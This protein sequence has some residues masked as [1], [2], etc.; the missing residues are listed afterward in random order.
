[1]ASGVSTQ[2]NN[3]FIKGEFKYDSSKQV[4]INRNNDTTI[5]IPDLLISESLTLSDDITLPSNL[6]VQSGGSLTSNSKTFTKESY[7]SGNITINTG[8]T[9]IQNTVFDSCGLVKLVGLDSNATMSSL[10]LNT[11]SGM[12]ISGGSIDV[13][14]LTIKDA[15]EQFLVTN[16]AHSG[17]ISNFTI[18]T[19][20]DHDLSFINMASGVSTEFNNVF[21]KGEFKYASSKEVLINRN[22]DTNITIPDLLISESLLVS[23]DISLSGNLVVQNGGL[24]SSSNK[25]FS[26]DFS[27][28]SANITI[29]TGSSSL[30]S[31]IFNSCGLLK[32]VSL[33]NNATMS[34]LTLNTC[35]GMEINGG[36]IDVSTLTIKDA[37][38]EFLVTNNAHSGTISNF[39]I[40]TTVD[41]DLSFINMASGVST[42]FN[43]VFIKGDFKYASSKPVL[44]NRNSDTNIT[45]PDLLIS[46]SLT[47]SDDITLP[48]NLVVQSSGS[49]ISNDKT[50]DKESYALGNITINTGSSSL[51]S[52]TFNS[53]GLLK[54]V[55]LDGNAT[56]S[57][58]TLN[59]CTGMEING[60][61][62]DV[63][64]LTIK[65]ASDEFLVT[66]N[67]HSG[68]ISNFTIH[69]TVDHDLS[70]I[71]M[72]SGVST[73]FNNVFIKGE[74]KYASSKPVLINRNSDTNITIPDLLISESLLISDD[75]TLPSNLVVESSGSLTADSKTFTKESYAP[76]N[77]TINTG[78]SSLQTIIFNSCGLLKLVGLDSNATISSLTLNNCTGMQIEGGSV[79]VSTI[80]INSAI[81]DYL[82]SDDHTG[83]VSGMTFDLDSNF[84]TN[85]L[86]KLGASTSTSTTLSGEIT[87]KSSD[88]N[89]ELTKDLVIFDVTAYDSNK[90]F[91]DVLLD[92]STEF[93]LD[94]NTNEYKIFSN[95]KFEGSVNCVGSKFVRDANANSNC[96]VTLKDDTKVFSDMSLESCGTLILDNLSTSSTISSFI[97]VSSP[98]IG[99][100][101]SGGSVDVSTLTIKDATGE[102][103]VTNNAH[104]GEISDFTI[105]T[106]VDHDLSFINMASG[107]STEFNNVF[108]KGDFKYA[109][110]KQ[111]LINRNSD[112][113][114]SIPDLLI[115]ESLTLSD[116]ITLPSNL[117][118][119][120]NGSLISNNKTIDKESYASGNITINTGSS[121]LQSTTFNSCGLLKLVSLDSNAT[122]SSLTLNTCTGMEING[123]S[124]DVSTLTIKDASDEFLVTNSAH[125]GTI[126]NLTIHTTVDHDL[127]FINMASGVS[128]AFNNVFIKGD[129]KYASSKPVLI[130][131]NN[132]TNITIPDLLISESL[133]VSDDI[134][135]PS[136]LVV[137]SSGSLTA[138]SKTFTKESYAS[139]NITINTGSSSLQTITFNSCGLL[140]LVGLDGNATMSSLTLNNCTGMQIEGGS[141]DVST[142]TINSATSDY[143]VSDDHTGTISGMTFDLDSNFSTNSLI[144]LGASTSTSTTLSGE[145][146]VKSSDTNV[147]LTKDLVIFDVTA[148]DS[149]ETFPDVLLDNSTEFVLDSNTN[150][151]KIF[152]NI[153]FEGSVNCV[154]SK[155]VRDVNANSN[156]NVT[157]KDDTK[158]F[159]EMS[160]ES[161]GT[162]ILDSLSTSSI[163]SSF[164]NV[165]SPTMG[166]Q[167]SG[168]SV[169]VSTLTVNSATGKYVVM[170][171]HS[172]EISNATFI[173][174]DSTTDALMDIQSGT[175]TFT[176]TT[177]VKATDTSVEFDKDLNIFDLHESY[178]SSDIPDIIFEEPSI[179]KLVS[180]E[181]YELFSNTTFKGTV[182]CDSAT[183][184]RGTG[185]KSICNITFENNNKVFTSMTLDNCGSLI[186]NSL[187]DTNSISLT[188]NDSPSNG[189]KIDGGSVNITSVTIKNSTNDYLISD[190]SHTG[191]ISSIIFDVNNNDNNLFKLGPNALTNSTLNGPVTIKSSSGAT[192]DA[193][194][195]IF[196][197]DNYD[198]NKTIP[199]VVLDNTTNFVLTSAETYELFSNIRFDG[200]VNCASATFSRGTGAN[201]TC[202]ITLKDDNKTFT[203]MT[204]NAC[205]HLKLDSL[206]TNNTIS[207]LTNNNSTNSGLHI[208]SGSVDVT[209]VTIKDAVGEFLVTDSSHSGTITSLTLDINNSHDESFINLG[210][211]VETS[212]VN[213]FV[214]G[215]F[216]H[217]GTKAKLINRNDDSNIVRPELRVSDSLTISSNMKLSSLLIVLPGG[218][219]SAENKTFTQD[220]DAE[221]GILILA[222][223]GSSDTYEFDEYS[224]LGTINYG[225]GGS[226]TIKSCTLNSLGTL[227][228]YSALTLVGCSKTNN[229]F[230]NIIVNDAKDSGISIYDGD[231][232]LCTTTIRDPVYNYIKTN[233]GHD[234]LVH[235]LTLTATQSHTYSLIDCG[236][237]VSKQD[238][239]ITATAF[240]NVT[241]TNTEADTNKNVSLQNTGTVN[242]GDTNTVVFKVNSG[243]IV[244]ING[245]KHSTSTNAFRASY[246]NLVSILQRGI[247]F[248]NYF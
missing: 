211:G 122:M 100:Q 235:G 107:V 159:T 34:S 175:T 128:T 96:N 164:T 236:N 17:T 183:I 8:S 6:V 173:L 5:S 4:L 105:H 196:S 218:T 203:G 123:G 208:T 87:V 178:T 215:T 223:D 78:S 168:G 113:N 52:T 193:N 199:D 7:A 59:T 116:D 189:L 45:I 37:S 26:K 212:F 110:S 70:F 82:V 127:S 194:L 167:I 111:V 115:S 245:I 221:G 12:K 188:N 13:S 67:A 29:N 60:G 109:S 246:D 207:N 24:L 152:S 2:F 112:S 149:N 201:A 129:F 101:I 130:N 40:H 233:W 14:T 3:V 21:I 18:H 27:D 155:F 61:S 209:T 134:T 23:D 160:L 216:E 191:S 71:N 239:G 50:I 30:Q 225:S 181:N 200:I 20:V 117:I 95:I 89:V 56:M 166:L 75:I 72:A 54:L 162:L 133:L 19:T 114:I 91:P 55:S 176:G 62:I 151:Y 83:T 1:M 158:V 234:G 170:S 241:Y 136:N 220:A 227:D 77:I 156:C 25:T 226:N 238:S 172:G 177:T 230:E 36:S 38:D 140:K 76:G 35:T 217:S 161:C 237:G 135:L 39:T 157:L 169:D 205:G 125:S 102:F 81:S 98:T 145:I 69:T 58:L 94:S 64:T 92:N 154:G 186:L 244:Y 31:T 224:S 163:I 228:K 219:I 195:S 182:N 204:I 198:T 108:I 22:S 10:T 148:Y 138:D 150:E 57:S 90:T 213:V 11:C 165:N 132:D 153:K 210:S 121:S 88:T 202:N 126:S 47:L 142:V 74:F 180:G 243:A 41:H 44:I 214:K 124:I 65:D 232:E 197:L 248:Y 49:L 79:D 46:D 85:S 185:A 66:N 147:E 93:V 190:N 86:I 97:N 106:T 51:Q 187:D 84:S 206:S 131:R 247:N 53:C 242:H 139:G 73:E 103:L 33:D 16:N 80:T 120:S 192:N 146:T 222:G 118:V 68:T 48:S 240:T 143:L 144:K 119:Q 171:S 42:E 43:N 28:T 174:S 231:V 229:S 63:S 9:S 15:S 141:V 179:F 184:S 137:Q 99:L 104:S 32:L